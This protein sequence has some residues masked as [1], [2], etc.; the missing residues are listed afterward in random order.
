MSSLDISEKIMYAR[1]DNKL[2]TLAKK[3]LDSSRPIITEELSMMAYTTKCMTEIKHDCFY[4]IHDCILIIGRPVRRSIM[5]CTCINTL[6]VGLNI[7]TV[8]PRQE[9]YGV[10][11]KFALNNVL[12]TIRFEI[13]SSSYDRRSFLECVEKVNKSRNA[14]TLICSHDKYYIYSAHVYN[15]NTECSCLIVLSKENEPYFEYLCVEDDLVADMG[16]LANRAK[17]NHGIN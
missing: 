6:M 8:I 16:I 14:V 10:N 9:I 11:R 4:F 3:V 17:L 2:V 7:M 12:S 13:I 15:E 1:S 5:R